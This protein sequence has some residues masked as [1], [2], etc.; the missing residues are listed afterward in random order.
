MKQEEAKRMI[1]TEWYK[2]PPEERK[3]EHQ[4]AVFAFKSQSRFHFKCSGDPYQCIM[5]CLMAN[6]GRD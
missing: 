3:T 1:L 6:I 5:G 2:L 4:A